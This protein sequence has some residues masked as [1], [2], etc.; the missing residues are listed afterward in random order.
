MRLGGAPAVTT[1]SSTSTSASSH[2]HSRR[3]LVPTS[4]HGRRRELSLAR[5]ESA[6]T[7]SAT[8][9]LPL[10]RR[11]FLR[12]RAIRA[13]STSSSSPL[14]EPS[15]DVI[16]K[17]NA[18]TTD[19][20][21]KKEERLAESKSKKLKADDVNK[22]QLSLERAQ[23]RL[24]A[25]RAQEALEREVEDAGDAPLVP[26]PVR[27]PVA[28][29][30]SSSSLSSSSGLEKPT[31]EGAR[32]RSRVIGWFGDVG[33]AIMNSRDEDD[34]LDADGN[35]RSEAKDG[36]IVDDE[37]DS[38][39]D[40]DIAALENTN[41][42]KE[43][44]GK[45]SKSNKKPT[46]NVQGGWF[47]WTDGWRVSESIE[48]ITSA[49]WIPSNVVVVGGDQLE[50][51]DDSGDEVD[52]L[53]RVPL[54]PW[55]RQ[56]L[57][58]KRNDPFS[59]ST[60]TQDKGEDEE[61]V[62]AYKGT[63]SMR[64][65]D[66]AIRDASATAMNVTA[67]AVDK[68]D[69][70]IRGIET[71]E[72]TA[73]KQG[74]FQQDSVALQILQETLKDARASADEARQANQALEAAVREVT[75]VQ[76][77]LKAGLSSEDAFDALE[78]AKAAVVRQATSSNAAVA[79]ALKQ[80]SYIA[81]RIEQIGGDLVIDDAATQSSKSQR[82]GLMGA[83]SNARRSAQD[84][85]VASELTQTVARLTSFAKGNDSA[86]TRKS[87]ADELSE[88]VKPA[89]QK[90]VANALTPVNDD[91]INSARLACTLSAWVYYLPQMQHALPRNGLRLITSSLDANE[92]IPS[93]TFRK[94]KN[95]VED[96]VERAEREWE[97]TLSAAQVSAKKD[98][99]AEMEA[100]KLAAEAVERAADAFRVAA[101]LKVE[102][103][104]DSEAA[105]EKTRI[106]K[107]LA[108]EAKSKLDAV[109][110]ISAANKRKI[111][112]W[113]MQ[114]ELAELENRMQKTVIE[115]Q[116]KKEAERLR[117]DRIEN[118]SLPVNFCVAAQDETATLWVV[119]EGSTNFASWQANLT[120]QPVTFEDESLGVH[121]HRGAYTA[122]KTMYRRV[123]QAVKEHVAKHGARARVRITG[124]SIGGSI[125]SILGLMLLVRNGAPRYALAD[126]WAFGAPY[127]MSGGDALL[128]RLGLPRTFMR[129]VMM[130]DDVVP[131]S[132][133]CYYPR[134]ARSILETAPGPFNVDTSGA[135]FLDEQMFYV[136]M[137]DLFM[138]Q[139]MNGDPHP[140]L[141]PG[142]GL[143]VLDGDGV[144]EMLATRARQ[145]E[146]VGDDEAWL[147]RR[148]S[149]S[150]LMWYDGDDSESD[151]DSE[152]TNDN[153][154]MNQLACLTQSDAAL[155]ASLIVSHIKADELLEREGGGIV[156]VLNERSRD[157]A[158][159]VLMNTP[160]PLTILSKPAAYG[161]HGIISRHHNP[162]NYSKALSN[163]RKM[164]SPSSSSRKTSQ[165]YIDG[166]PATR[167]TD[168]K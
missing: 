45:E 160:H 123:E 69:S 166:A 122:A 144:Y 148:R 30:S 110:E 28:V 156:D 44:K 152:E 121:V 62:M 124:H 167:P 107:Q 27:E 104:A 92:V 132:F 68:L 19:E 120:F 143:Y 95:L 112:K 16:D 50:N 75:R 55:I 153:L 119:V 85:L 101:E 128:A 157:A 71:V 161:D 80:L 98:V 130:G 168:S 38:E 25:F 137:G 31:E 100:S 65:V 36:V 127:V 145:G 48:N 111:E 133:S 117:T 60:A 86:A 72:E 57:F 146:D 79:D 23:A 129:V 13:S 37:R 88:M 47:R 159:R 73:L 52:L 87:Q 83:I 113:K 142:P 78:Q 125:A 102:S 2:S 106:A 26:S 163:A 138:L 91:E 40:D 32:L 93:A 151:S 99:V 118:A 29:S 41:E 46:P 108:L 35:V 42:D 49:S 64:S 154:G 56:R 103:G 109:S 116:K 67:A 147:N 51:T 66:S 3:S 24:A 15:S 12:R 39:S 141:P 140:L 22:L 81:T 136:P 165:W 18:A 96:S 34:A 53:Q 74:K 43:E 115:Q 158:Q 162:F 61:D 149:V 5:S 7:R 10:R 21:T 70:A 89:L 77:G 54:P 126:I 14:E 59:S 135:N 4:R 105:Q 155:T 33:R 58:G 9:R 131:R 11:R 82:R 90:V 97:Q 84:A 1:A 164:K 94:G 20:P 150:D 114:Y 8:T 63:I 76:E 139:A 6:V 17:G 134:W